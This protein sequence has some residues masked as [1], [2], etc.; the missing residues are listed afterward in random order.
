MKTILSSI[1]W[2]F[3]LLLALFFVSV[4]IE[5]DAVVRSEKRM[6]DTEFAYDD[7]IVRHPALGE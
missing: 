5:Q 7:L 4:L 2:A 3:L 1:A 6:Q